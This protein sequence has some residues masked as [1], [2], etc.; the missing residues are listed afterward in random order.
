MTARTRALAARLALAVPGLLLSAPAASALDSGKA[1]TQYVMDNWRVEHGL[2]M[3]SVKGIAQTRDGYLWFG[4]QEGLVRFDGVRFTVFDRRNTPALSNHLIVDL[5]AARDGALWIGTADGAVRLHDGA[6]TRI[7]RREGLSNEHVNA[8]CEDADGSMWIGTHQGLN[9]LQ[10]GRVTGYTTAQG[11]VHDYVKA[12]WRDRDGSLWIATA[13]GLSRF[14]AGR[15]TN[16][17]ARDGL[18]GDVLNGVFQDST[19]VVWVGS[20]GGLN[21]LADG[22]IETV[23]GEGFERGLP[24]TFAE[25]ADG[26]VWIGGYGGGL[27][28]FRNGRFTRFTTADGLP[29]DLLQTVYADR[30]GGLWVATSYAGLVRLKDGPLTTITKREGLA[31]DAAR[32]VYEDAAGAIWI[33]TEGGGLTRWQAGSAT[34]FGMRDGLLSDTVFALQGARD[35]GLWIG[36]YNGGLNRYQRGRFLRHPVQ[37][38]RGVFV[39]SILEDPDGVLWLGTYGGGLQ[40]V[41]GTLVESFGEQAGLGRTVWAVVRD[42]AGALW[43]GSRYGLFRHE[44]NGFRRYTTA[45]GLPDDN[46]WTL[47]A[48]EDGTLWIGTQAGLARHRGGRIDRLVM[49]ERPFDSMIMQLLPDKQGYLWVGTSQGLFRVNKGELEDF[50]AGARTSVSA[51]GYGT[52]DGMKSVECNG[53]TQPAAWRAGD[54]RLWFPTSKGIVVVDTARLRSTPL[55]PAPLV[56]LAV[57]DGRSLSAGEEIPPGNHRFEFH[58][59]SPY[60]S[61][62]RRIRF[63]Y[64]LEGVD[65]RW[66]EV[67][68]TQRVAHYT[69]LPPGRHRF[70]VTVGTA[71]GAWREDEAA[72]EFALAPHFHQTPWF[73]ALC[74]L[75]VALLAYGGHRYRVRRLL[76]VERVRTRIASDLH[77]DIGASLSQIA[78]LSEVARRRVDTGEATEPLDRIGRLS[79]ESVDA[80]SDIVWAIDPQKDRLAH[81]TQRLRGLAAEVLDPA[82]LDYRFDADDPTQDVR[83]GADVRRQ[84]FLVFKE[85]LNNVVR[86]SG[87][88]HVDIRLVRQDGRLVLRIADDGRGFDP[89]AALDGNGLRSMRRRAEAVAGTLDLGPS[90]EGTA[91]TLSIPT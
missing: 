9:H 35:G 10:R 82:G 86:H 36:T 32:V 21:R 12:L 17:T 40:R 34:H 22:R 7:G 80:M 28:R 63:R 25:D 73:Y 50:A 11:L 2:P 6:G 27:H 4:T 53:S 62:P 87:A 39:T 90:A 78:I 89:A 68:G 79:R 15:F 52:A 61:D 58:Y 5:L 19:G 88:R 55:P 46:V 69:N 48:E 54:G 26:N 70:R 57:V 64:R 65:D 71:E 14:R 60:L 30:E 38:P 24:G 29:D 33:G 84:V 51:T 75:G 13:G 45:D 47:A 20:F 72:V 41:Q 74:A 42:S 8:L 81:L 31:H 49:P 91:V 85:A 16:L 67:S 1:I 77:D 18:A 59:T 83:L 44:G 43:A 37:P 3:D 56:E 76:E 66:I 23:T